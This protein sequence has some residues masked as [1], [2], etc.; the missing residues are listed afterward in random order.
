MKKELRLQTLAK[1]DQM[2]AEEFERNTSLLYEQLFQLPAWKQAEML[3]LTMS[4]GKEVPT[5]P[6]MKKA[7]QEGKTVCVPTCFPDT[8][9]MTFYEYTPHTKMKSSYFGLTEPDPETSAAVHKEAIDLMIVPGVCFDQQGYRVGY[10]GGYYDRY[11]ADYHGVTL[12][13][14]LSV[15]QIE[16][17][18]AETH[19]IPVSMI[20]SEK[21]TFYLR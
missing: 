8:K 11:L 5:R 7:W 6:L 1:L 13:L 21:G 14:C 20:V 17:V 4:R 3:A 10:G 12:A 15:Q 19:D 16:H 18:P 2:S 9:D